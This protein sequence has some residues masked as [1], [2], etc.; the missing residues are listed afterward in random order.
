MKD[1][2][3]TL[4][5]KKCKERQK[6][7]FDLLLAKSN[8][9]DLLECTNKWVINHS[10]RQ[11]NL[12]EKKALSKGLNF[13]PAPKSIPIPRI[14]AAVETGLRIVPSSEA[15]LARINIIG[16]LTK[17]KP[18]PSNITTE[19]YRAIKDLIKDNSI[20]I[21]PTDK[22][23]ATVILDKSE[24]HQKI[25]SMLSD[26]KTYKK[27]KRDPALA[28]ERKMNSLLLSLKRA[29]SLPDALYYRLRSSAKTTPLLYGL[30]KIHKP[31]TPLRPIVS[32]INSPT[33]ILS[34]HLVTI[35]SPLVGNS[36]THV[37][38]S[39]DF[40]KFI[41]TAMGS[42][43]SVTVANLVMED[44]E[45]KGIST[46]PSPP[47]FWKRFVDDIITALPKVSVQP[48]LNHLN[49]IEETINFTVELE[50][51][52]ELSF[53]DT[54]VKHNSNGTLSTT[55]RRTQINTCLLHPT[56]P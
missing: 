45:D 31:N 12:I 25:L 49:S 1:N 19:E 54:T 10:S 8:K 39:F 56:I 4:L 55:R 43:V 38:N 53:L 27:L 41:S 40:S 34:K 23:R 28:L 21:L 2:A 33:Y 32:F 48:F 18:P 9:E 50:S 46:Y 6:H 26:D 16:A 11:L 44:I 42:P 30:P 13:T 3:Q 20:L 36:S 15:E 51:N 37:K 17:A 52:G 24:Y 29:G 35:L 5:T 47:P 14:V 7:K 22:G